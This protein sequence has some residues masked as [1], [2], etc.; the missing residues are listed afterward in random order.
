MG[1]RQAAGAPAA[2]A[3][4]P[5]RP[6]LDQPSPPQLY[7]SP[8]R[9]PWRKV[10]YERQPHGD[11]Y[12]GE[13]FLEEL[14]VNATVRRPSASVECGRVLWWLAACSTNE[15]AAGLISCFC[16]SLVAAAAATCLSG[17]C[18]SLRSLSSAIRLALSCVLSAWCDSCA[19]AAPRLRHSG[20][21]NAGG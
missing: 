12:T 18:A 13:S 4:P 1:R 9:R 15:H 7:A 20:L 19:G 16:W 6:T 2:A 11:A 3:V 8:P 10:L 14:V 21:V 5:E 17:P